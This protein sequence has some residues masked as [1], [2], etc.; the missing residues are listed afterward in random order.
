VHEASGVGRGQCIADSSHDLG[1]L[2]RLQCCAGHEEVAQVVS[3]DVL[4]DH[5]IGLVLGGAPVVDRH[6]VGVG[7]ASRGPGLVL[8]PVHELG[9]VRQGRVEDLYRHGPVEKHI[10]A[11]IDLAHAPGGETRIEPIAAGQSL[12]DQVLHEAG[13]QFLECLR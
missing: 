12:S 11:P 3:G 6:D 1:R 7:E 9:V 13:H 2:G 8:E 10:V 4:H 5:V